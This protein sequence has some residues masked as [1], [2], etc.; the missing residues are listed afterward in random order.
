[1]VVASLLGAEHWIETLRIEVTV[2]YLVAS[3]GQGL[4]GCAMQGRI[5]AIAQR[6]AVQNQYAHGW[7]PGFALGRHEATGLLVRGSQDHGIP[8][9]H[10][11][12]DLDSQAWAVRC[13]DVPVDHHGGSDAELIAEGVDP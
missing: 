4:Q 1:M 3:I 8:I 13:L 7:S 12:I 2:V 6:V 10:R 11:F 9:D 5:E